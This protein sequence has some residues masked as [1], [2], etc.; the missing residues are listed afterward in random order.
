ALLWYD[1]LLSMD[2]EIKFVWSSRTLSASLLY[3]AIRYPIT[4]SSVMQFDS[5]VPIPTSVCLQVCICLFLPVLINLKIYYHSCLPTGWVVFVLNIVGI[6]GPSIFTTFRTYALSGRNK[7]LGIVS[8][9][10][11]LTP[12]FINVV[13]SLSPSHRRVHNFP[14]PNNCAIAWDASLFLLKAFETVTIASRV[15]LILVDSL[16]LVV[17]W[18]QAYNARQTIHG[19]LRRGSLHGII[20][21]YGTP[22]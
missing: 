2:R 4:L 20:L 6:I 16:A 19:A 10:L 3:V 21:N 8:L 15:S 13:S 22:C 12:F 18:V 14:A 9:V 11:G 7:I 17:T 1:M 5:L